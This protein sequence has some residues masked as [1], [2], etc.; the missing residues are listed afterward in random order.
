MWR[1]DAE[2]RTLNTYVPAG[3][4][5]QPFM[6]M[7]GVSTGWLNVI[8][9]FR[10]QSSAFTLEENAAAS[11]AAQKTVGIA[12]MKVT[13]RKKHGYAR[14]RV[15]PEHYVKWYRPMRKED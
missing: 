4:T 3:N 8:T 11:S 14:C 6:W 9:V 7:P 1:S 15:E 12:F 10:F 2:S 13:T 5:A